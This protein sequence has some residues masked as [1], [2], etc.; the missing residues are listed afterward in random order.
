MTKYYTFKMSI[1]IWGKCVDA[2]TKPQTLLLKVALSSSQY[3]LYCLSIFID[4]YSV[5]FTFQ[6]VL[7]EQLTERSAG[8]IHRDLCCLRP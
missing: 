8:I 2:K 5:L 4:L 7:N 1:S 6:S 3:N